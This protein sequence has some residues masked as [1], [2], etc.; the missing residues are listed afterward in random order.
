MCEKRERA[1]RFIHPSPK[2][3]ERTK[4][5]GVGSV[6]AWCTFESIGSILVDDS[7]RYLS[8][9]LSEMFDVGDEGVGVGGYVHA[10]EA[11]PV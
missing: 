7:T 10:E 5:V 4:C 6:W 8:V 9:D 11:R 2:K 1:P 3:D